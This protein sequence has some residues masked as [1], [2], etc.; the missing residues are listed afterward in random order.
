MND[1]LVWF[2]VNALADWG[3]NLPDNVN[4]LYSK[5]ISDWSW[6]EILIVYEVEGSFYYIDDNVPFAAR[7]EEVLQMMIGFEELCNNA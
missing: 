2:D 1:D 6:A 7:Q 4:L 3:I 5:Q